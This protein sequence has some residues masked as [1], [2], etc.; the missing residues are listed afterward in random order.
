MSQS[1]GTFCLICFLLTITP[2]ADTALILKSADGRNWNGYFST[3]L[4]ICAG[5]ICYATLSALGLSA[6]FV[7][8]AQLFSVVKAIGAGYLIYLGI[9]NL[10]V[11][12]SI[13]GLPVGD[14]TELNLKNRSRYSD[15]REG[16]LTNISNQSY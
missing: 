13:I 9:K 3:T 2:G 7:K 8:S 14:D 12:H 6:I 4:G 11:A 10:L 15:F 16:L 5:L 1:F